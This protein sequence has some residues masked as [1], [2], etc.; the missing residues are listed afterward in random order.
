[1][2]ATEHGLGD[3]LYTD[4]TGLAG[5]DMTRSWLSQRGQAQAA[6]RPASVLMLF[7]RGQRPRTL[8]GKQELERLHGLGVGDA[9]VLLLKRSD[10]LRKHPGQVA[11]PGGGQDAEDADAIAAALRE[12]HEETGVTESGIRIAGSLEPVWVPVSGFEVTPVLAWWEIPEPVR[13][14]DK[15]ESQSVY[16][17]AVADLVAPAN[18]GT[19]FL[20]GSNIQ[21]P[22][23]DVGV[24][25]IWGMTAGLLEF[26]LDG[27]GWAAP[28]DKSNSIIIPNP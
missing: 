9:D 21:S 25:K 7:G 13:V 24:L 6:V 27:M 26:A 1:M 8:A 14:V 22:A 20:P 23:F 28:Y 18:R 15:R 11:F 12:A 16:R 17:V 3:R 10:K 19:F 4:L 2:S 5:A